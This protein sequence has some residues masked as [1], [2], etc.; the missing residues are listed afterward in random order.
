[1][2]HYNCTFNMGDCL[3]TL[4]LEEKGRVQQYVTNEVIKL[5]DPYVP[6]QEGT[7]KESVHIENG[8]DV[9]YG[10]AASAYANYQWNGIV[11]ED[12]LLHCAG[13]EVADGGWRSRKGI[14]KVP[15]DRKLQYQNGGLRG[16][17]WVERMLQNGGLEKIE[18]G[19]RRVVSK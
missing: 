16:A 14:E 1:M 6:F 2:A 3:K 8:T 5:S 12:P 19:I 13:F 7:L 17:K 11:Y 18:A 4:G 9:V 15:T 10:G